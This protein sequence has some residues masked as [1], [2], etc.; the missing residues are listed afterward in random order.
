LHTSQPTTSHQNL[1]AYRDIPTTRQFAHLPAQYPKKT[2]S[3]THFSLQAYNHL[4][5]HLTALFATCV[6]IN[7][8]LESH[9]LPSMLSY[10][11]Q[12]GTVL[13]FPAISDTALVNVTPAT[14]FG[15]VMESN[16]DAYPSLT[17]PVVTCIYILMGVSRRLTDF[18]QSHIRLQAQD[19][20][21]RVC[22]VYA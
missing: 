5:S 21:K 16:P 4:T 12:N 18:A 6:S 14:F 11:S 19:M 20:V 7:T 10:T 15:K 13:L 3:N 8:R 17:R 2:R 9:L 22:P 1:L